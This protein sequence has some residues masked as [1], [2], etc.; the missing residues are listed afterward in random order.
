MKIYS[1]I[2]SNNVMFG[3]NCKK[4][5]TAAKD[6]NKKVF[7]TVE[8]FFTGKKPRILSAK[9]E[10]KINRYMEEYSQK[11]AKDEAEAIQTSEH[12][13]LNV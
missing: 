13:Y 12:I 1:I 6:I 10:S 8:D 9:V 2:D 4:A 3:L 11:L 7:P 5:A